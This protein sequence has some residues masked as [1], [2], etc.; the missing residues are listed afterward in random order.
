MS[1]YTE[2]SFETVDEWR[3]ECNR[4]K[5]AIDNI[6]KQIKDGYYDLH[7][8]CDDLETI[9]AIAKSAREK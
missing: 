1:E 4:L 8:A 7:N 5:E 2:D 6:L 9:Q 3:N